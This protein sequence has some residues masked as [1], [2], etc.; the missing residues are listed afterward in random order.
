[1][2]DSCCV[3]VM[4][5]GYNPKSGRHLP[6]YLISFARLAFQLYCTSWS[7]KWEGS[8]LGNEWSKNVNLTKFCGM[9]RFSYLTRS[10]HF[11]S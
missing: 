3:V 10:T 9:R 2:R 5:V 7:H 11:P 1:M 8:S 4:I 6:R